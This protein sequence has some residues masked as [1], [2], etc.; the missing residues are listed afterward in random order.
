VIDPH[1]IAQITLDERTVIRRSADIEHERRV[2]IYDL[3]EANS[4]QPVGE[5]QGPYHVLMGM[6]EN[7]LA[8][9]IN[10]LSDTP[11]TRILLPLTPFRRIIRDYFTICESYFQAIKSASPSKIEAI[12]MGRR[13]LHNEGSNLLRERLDGRV[14]LDNETARR[15]FTLV[16]IIQIRS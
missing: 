8:L 2:A 12:D 7:R 5:F 14:V 6:E 3:L 1:R 10:D 15:L 11:L 16:C 13:G 4:F 9:D